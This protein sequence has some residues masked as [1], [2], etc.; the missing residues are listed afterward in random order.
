[1]KRIQE[2]SGTGPARN[3]IT[4]LVEAADDIV[5]STGDLV[6]GVKKGVITWRTIEERLSDPETSTAANRALLERTR[7]YIDRASPALVGKAYEEALAQ[8]FATLAVGTA[9]AAT[10]AT[11]RS[12]YP[13]IANGTYHGTLIEDSDA[14]GLIGLCKQLGLDYVYVSNDTLKLEVMGYH[15]IQ[16]LLTLFWNESLAGDYRDGRRMPGKLYRLMSSNYKRVYE[17]ALAQGGFPENY[18]K[19]QLVTDYVCGMTDSFAVSI[20]HELRYG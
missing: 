3:P 1:V 4:Y 17:Q 5:Y 14:A 11:F 15:I 19:L 16:D 18:R 9:V 13:D 8:Y 2:E 6:D 10:L 7:A 20:H 12:I